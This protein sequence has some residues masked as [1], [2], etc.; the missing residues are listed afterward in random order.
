MNTNN[1]LSIFINTFIETNKNLFIKLMNKTFTY[2]DIN[3]TTLFYFGILCILIGILG[4]I[5]N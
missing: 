4:L 3:N 1:T 5:L 2:D